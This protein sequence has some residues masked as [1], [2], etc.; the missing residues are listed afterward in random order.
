MAVVESG[1]S[2]VRRI[3][4]DWRTTLGFSSI[5][6]CLHFSIRKGELNTSY[7]TKEDIVCKADRKFVTGDEISSGL[8]TRHANKLLKQ[9]ELSDKRHGEK[10]KD[11]ED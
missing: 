4:T 11:M 7:S 6:T 1:F 8:S 5:N 9:Y 3:I 10:R 2:A